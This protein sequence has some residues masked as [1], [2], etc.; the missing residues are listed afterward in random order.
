LGSWEENWPIHFHP[1]VLLA[2][3]E[4]ERL[5]PVKR[6]RHWTTV[7]TQEARKPCGHWH[8]PIQIVQLPPYASWCTPSENLWRKLKQE[9]FHLHPWADDLPTLRQHILDFFKPFEGGSQEL[10][11]SVGL[12]FPY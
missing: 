6:P 11:H 1:D 4:Q 7:P 3:Q 10:L 5:S 2:L 12:H 8:L 9:L